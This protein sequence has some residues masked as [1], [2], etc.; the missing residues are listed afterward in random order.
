MKC[1]DCDDQIVHTH[2]LL[3]PLVPDVTIMNKKALEDL[4]ISIGLA[5]MALR[6]HD[7]EI[8]PPDKEK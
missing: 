7:E 4:D 3:H 1:Q 8:D 5:L 2:H 6:E